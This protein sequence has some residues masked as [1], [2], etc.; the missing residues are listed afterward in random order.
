MKKLVL[1]LMVLIYTNYFAQNQNYL[2]KDKNQPIEKRVENLLGLMTLEEKI[3]MMGGTGFATQPIERL[4]IPTLNMADGPLGVRWDNSTAFPSGIAMSCTWDTTLINKLGVAL[5]EETKAHGRNVILGPCVNIARIPMG[6][7]NFESFGEDPF[8]AAKMGVSYIKGVQSKNVVATVKHYAC[9]NQEHERMTVNTIVD[10]RTLNEIYLPAFKAAVKDANVLAVM[11]A[12]NKVNGYYAT[13]NDYLL[14]DKLKKEWDFKGLV[15]SDWGAVHSS[16]GVYNSGL[17]LEMPKGDY[18]NEPSFVKRLLNGEFD[19]TKLDDKVRRILTVMFKIGLFDGYE[20]PTDKLNSDEHKKLAYQIAVDGMVLLKNNYSILPIDPAV[21]KSIA[22]IGPNANYARTGGGGSSLVAPYYKVSPL[23][24]LKNK[25][26][27]LLDITYAPGVLLDGDAPAVEEKYFFLDEKGT[28]PGVKVKYYNSQEPKGTPVV[29]KTEPKIENYWFNNSP[30]EGINSEHFSI[31]YEGYLKFPKSGEAIITLTSDDGSR[32]YFDNKL[33]IDDWNDHAMEARYFKVNVE[34]DK[35]YKFKIEYY[36]NM[37][38]A[39]VVLGCI[40]PEKDFIKQAVEAAANSDLA[41]LFVGN[42]AHYETEGKDRDDLYL[43]NDQDK[44]INEVL[45]AN[46]NVVVVI[47]TGSPILMYNW[48]DKVPAV[49]QTWFAGQEIGNAVVDILFGLANPS[50]KL[51]ITYPNKWE[52]CSAYNYYK[53]IP[54][55][56]EYKDSIYVG[57]RHFEKYGI[58]PLFPFGYGLSYTSYKHSNFKV[59]ETQDSYIVNFDVE[60]TGAFAGKEIVQLYISPINPKI[61]RPVKELKGFVKVPLKI[62]EKKNAEITV[63]KKDFAYFSVPKNSFVL[64]SGD[65]LIQLGTS[66][67]NIIFEQKVTI[68]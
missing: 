15:M 33:V 31:S 9:N 61:D 16:E 6:G 2:Y 56:T 39:G 35:L 58:K 29:E 40:M 13:E 20:Y 41:I 48:I 28:L 27:N 60:N 49:L 36:E 10:E 42:S 7:R 62:K 34:K 32:F 47:T 25:F 53:K 26:G 23:E 8:L 44:L 14:I 50:G 51:T 17:D 30:I 11:A 19:L 45:K 38:D 52:D 22:V 18:L 63:N 37:G 65:Y 68:K 57:Y 67:Q 1:L 43:P 59:T 3:L 66:S 64:D 46:K 24:A 4:G 5:A 55:V 21:V 12:Y 54:D